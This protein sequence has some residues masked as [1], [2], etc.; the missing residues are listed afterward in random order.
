MTPGYSGSYGINGVNFILQP[1]EAGWGSR[2]ELGIDGNG[3]P[4][5]PAVR[6]F[7]FNWQLAHPNDVKQILDAWEIVSNT[8]TVSFD[9]PQWGA[10][11]YLFALYSG[12]TM[13]EPTVG[14]Y[15]SE[16]IKDVRL[17]VLL[18]RT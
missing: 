17:T 14:M 2:S 10:S 9:L 7:E 11:D 18:V 15:F 6:Q 5:Y 16:W 3:H 1:T 13:R 4:I 12:C 8:G